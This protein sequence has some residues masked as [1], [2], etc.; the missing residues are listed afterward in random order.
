MSA[1]LLIP[2]TTAV[3]SGCASILS[4]SVMDSYLNGGQDDK[5]RSY[6]AARHWRSDCRDTDWDCYR[7]L[8]RASDAFEMSSRRKIS[9][10]E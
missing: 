6:K 1:A 5:R 7:I 2:H 3:I 9:L 4:G 8:S 10:L